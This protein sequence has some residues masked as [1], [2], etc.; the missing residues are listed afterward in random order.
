MPDN[1]LDNELL[2]NIAGNGTIELCLY[3]QRSK[4]GMQRGNWK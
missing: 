2:K 1:T 3:S 4:S